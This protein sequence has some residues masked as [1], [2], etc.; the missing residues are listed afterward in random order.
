M[1]RKNGGDTNR[2]AATAQDRFTFLTDAELGARLRLA[3]Y[4]ANATISDVV[5]YCLERA[6]EGYRKAHRTP[7]VIRLRP[8][9][10]IRLPR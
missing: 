10:R 7:R 3:A 2:T 1:T 5:A 8:G 6:L 9:K 4:E